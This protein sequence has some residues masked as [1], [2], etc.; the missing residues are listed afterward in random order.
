MF[1]RTE[2]FSFCFILIILPLQFNSKPL[3]DYVHDKDPL[4]NWTLIETYTEPDYK[5]YI[6]NYT[7]L[8]WY[9]GKLFCRE[10]N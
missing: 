1:L 8:K 3:D 10:F 2:I 5:L 7:S 4:Y 9:D 6:L